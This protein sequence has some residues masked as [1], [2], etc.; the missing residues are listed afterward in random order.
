MAELEVAALGAVVVAVA[1]VAGSTAGASVGRAARAAAGG[2]AG[3]AA[4]AVAGDVA[5][6]AVATVAGTAVGAAAGSAAVEVGSLALDEGRALSA[7]RSEV[8]LIG[9]PIRLW[10]LPTIGY[11]GAPAG[12]SVSAWTSGAALLAC[13]E[14]STKLTET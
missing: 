11:I 3:G 5:D 2:A 13:E 14:G 1:V 8:T 7:T 4:A 10:T 12:T 6:A 9:E